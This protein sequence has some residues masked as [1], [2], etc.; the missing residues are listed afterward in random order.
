MET[1][2]FLDAHCCGPALASLSTAAN[3]NTSLC[4]CSVLMGPVLVEMPGFE[5]SHLVAE[6]VPLEA[7]GHVRC[8]PLGR[9]W[10]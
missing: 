8:G 9:S 7:D 5:M 2:P 10:R 6:F 3:R 1:T 4:L